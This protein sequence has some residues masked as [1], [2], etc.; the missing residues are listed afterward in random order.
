MRF[1]VEWSNEI[2]FNFFG[3]FA[4]T[5]DLFERSKVTYPPKGN[6]QRQYG[7]EVRQYMVEPFEQVFSFND[8]RYIPVVGVQSA[9]ANYGF[10]NQVFIDAGDLKTRIKGIC[11]GPYIAGGIAGVSIGSYTEQS[12]FTKASRDKAGVDD[13]GFLDDMF[14][15]QA[16]MSQKTYNQNHKTFLADKARYATDNGMAADRYMTL[17]YEFSWQHYNMSPN[18]KVSLTGAINGTTLTVSLNSGPPLRPDDVL[19]K[20]D[21]TTGTTVIRQI[22]G[23]LGGAG[24]YEVSISQTSASGTITTSTSMYAR[25][26]GRLLAQALRDPRAG[27]A[28]VEQMKW[29]RKDDGGIHCLFDHTGSAPTIW[30]EVN[31]TNSTFGSVWGMEDKIGNEEIDDPYKSVKAYL[32][33]NG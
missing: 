17:S 12:I 7:I 20:S 1:V 15:A 18:N 2:Y 13:A 3:P 23:T 8:P 9:Q 21:I 16:V 30:D 6:L 29:L 27:V 26:V 32:Q 33:A 22:N 24:D 5:G 28:Q 4:Q 31:N 14:A 25:A 11:T 10:I 19:V